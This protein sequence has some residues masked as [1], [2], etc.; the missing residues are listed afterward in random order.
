MK[1]LFA[2]FKHP[3]ESIAKKDSASIW[4]LIWFYIL[5][6]GIFLLIITPFSI[7]ETTP[8]HLGYFDKAICFLLV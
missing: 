7:A 5:M 3:T 2:Y 8:K 1:K 4:S 6:Q